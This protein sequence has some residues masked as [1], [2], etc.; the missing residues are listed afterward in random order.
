ML[1]IYC[2]ELSYFEIETTFDKIFTRNK[3]DHEYLSL[4][5]DLI[6]PVRNPSRN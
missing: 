2:F 1:N 6:I 5:C 4:S 3:V